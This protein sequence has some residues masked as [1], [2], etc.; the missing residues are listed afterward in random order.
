MVYVYTT[1]AV[2]ANKSCGKPNV[3]KLPNLGMMTM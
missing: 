1:H 3:I 2:N